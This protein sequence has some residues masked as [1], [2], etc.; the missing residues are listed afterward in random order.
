MAILAIALPSAK[1]AYPA[2][3]NCSLFRHH[4]RLLPAFDNKIG[5]NETPYLVS[6]SGMAKYYMG[7]TE[8]SNGQTITVEKYGVQTIE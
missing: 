8:N 7:R 2:Y 5:L 3:G 1:S 4:C 6:P